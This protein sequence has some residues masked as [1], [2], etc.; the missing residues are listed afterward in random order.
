[1]IK[2]IIFDV[3]KVLIG[4]DPRLSMDMIGFSED[5]KN[6]VM[7][8]L[9][10]KPGIWDAEDRSALSREELFDF[11]ASQDPVHGD[12]IRRYYADA[13]ISASPMPYSREWISKLKS[14]GFN[15]YVLSN[16]G[17]YAQKASVE[18]GA[19][20]FLDLVD[21]YV[22]S[23]QIHQV[24]PEPEIYNYLM[25]KYNLL[26]EESVFI[27]DAP[28]NI[29]GAEKVGIKGILFTGYEDAINQLNVLGVV[30]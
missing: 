16:F 30:Y 29:A 12:L 14:A 25:E 6:I 13:V 28:R 8:A 27:D 5:E 23:W 4:W 1:M 17:E 19:I 20:N 2:N 22:F 9:F 7:E 15:V 21:G 18:K 10:A 11:F 3:G 26:P 24:K